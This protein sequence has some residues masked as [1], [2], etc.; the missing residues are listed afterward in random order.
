MRIPA[1]QLGI[2]LVCLSITLL[3]FVDRV[4]QTG[5]IYPYT[6]KGYVQD[7]RHNPRLLIGGWFLYKA[8][9]LKKLKLLFK[10]K[11]K[12][13]LKFIA[14][15]ILL[16]FLIGDKMNNI[17]SPTKSCFREAV[18]ICSSWTVI[19]YHKSRA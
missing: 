1:V 19:I 18:I 12:L 9:K 8:I 4:P 17:F 6:I 2:G 10:L 14:K 3:V 15:K 11:K 7:V 13:K 16:K 5:A